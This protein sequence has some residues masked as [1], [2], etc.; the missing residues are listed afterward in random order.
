VCFGKRQ[1]GRVGGLCGLGGRKGGRGSPLPPHAHKITH[2]ATPPPSSPP[3][4]LTPPPPPCRRYALLPLLLQ[5]G[6]RPAAASNT[7]FAAGLT[8]Y[9]YI[10][11][12]GYNELPFLR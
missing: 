5:D 3:H 8:A 11:F 4:S 2:P 7:L 12:L 6:F 1:K 10:V 9:C